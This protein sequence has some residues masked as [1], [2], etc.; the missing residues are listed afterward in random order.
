[1]LNKIKKICLLLF[2]IYLASF[3]SFA[4]VVSDNDGSAFIT[5]SEFDSLKNDFQSQ[6]DKYNSTID[7]KID[8]AISQYLAGINAG[9]G[10]KY[11]LIYSG[12]NTHFMMGVLAPEF[13]VPS[14]NAIVSV[15][16]RAPR[17]INNQKMY[18]SE[19]TVHYPGDWS[20]NETQKKPLIKLCSDYSG[21]N[22]EQYPNK[23]YWDGQA[24]R[25]LEKVNINSYK[26]YQHNDLAAFDR[27]NS[28]RMNG[29][30]LLYLRS[31]GYNASM[32][33]QNVINPTVT[34]Q[35]QSGS[36][37]IS[38]ASSQSQLVYYVTNKFFV[39]LDD[40]A[41][42]KNGK[43]VNITKDH[44]H[45]VNYTNS[46]WELYNENFTN[47]FHLSGNQTITEANVITKVNTNSYTKNAGEYVGQYYGSASDYTGSIGSMPFNIVSSTN[48]IASV[49]KLVNTKNATQINQFPKD[50]T[51][52]FKKSWDFGNPN[53]R[54]GMPAFA[55]EKDDEITL[56]VYFP[57]VKVYTSSTAQSTNPDGVEV[58]VYVSTGTF[59]DN[60]GIVS[61]G[62]YI[63]FTD[64]D[65][66]EQNYFTTTN[67]AGTLKW[68]MPVSSKIYIK[69]RPRWTSGTSYMSNNWDI[70]MDL[71]SDDYKVVSIVEKGL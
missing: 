36:S 25:Y 11:G 33:S 39:K 29:Q 20:T 62:Q 69:C 55:A 35:Y 31:I 51:Y 68:T 27:T 13:R 32:V 3:N 24:L 71:E 8:D 63:K 4:A 15:S 16:G 10:K 47:T 59:T 21:T 60:I 45:V 2:S 6:I 41:I 14:I 48:K 22:N 38:A 7:S 65:G 34:P 37:W 28:K 46:T 54:Q 57:N 61:S 40:Y 56:K 53:L 44:L 70:E 23:V 9:V 49:G 5:K 66:V 18:S 17:A 1:M 58:D 64:S 67:R 52:L 42:T 50:T 43:T 19:L 26:I 12:E 30:Y